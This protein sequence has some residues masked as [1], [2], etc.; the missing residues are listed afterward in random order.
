MHSLLR[1]LKLLALLSYQIVIIGIG[2]K[3]VRSLAFGVLL[4][5]LKSAILKLSELMSSLAEL[6]L[7]L[8]ILRLIL[9]ISL[10]ALTT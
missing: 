10:D 8:E 9:F 6:Y 7:L 1:L 4:S 3:S 2:A 5:E